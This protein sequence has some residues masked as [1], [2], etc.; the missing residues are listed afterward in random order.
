MAG[1]YRYTRVKQDKR[2]SH[3]QGSPSHSLTQSCP[4]Y[5]L[6]FMK[7]NIFPSLHARTHTH[8]HLCIYRSPE[9]V[10]GHKAHNQNTMAA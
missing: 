9:G 6:K 2:S 3:T 8:T 10:L 7:N 4:W 1:I 5:I